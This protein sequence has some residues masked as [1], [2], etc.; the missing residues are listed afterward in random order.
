LTLR[1]TAH[2]MF[3]N[4]Q[5]VQIKPGDHDRAWMD[6]TYNRFAYRCLP[7]TIANQHGWQVQ[8]TNRIQARWNGEN[9]ERDL[10][11]SADAGGTAC[12]IFGYGILTFQIMHLIRTPPGWNLYITGAPNYV[13]PGIQPLTG[14][15]ETDWAPYS[16]TMNWQ[17][18]DADRDICFEPGDP[19]CFFFPIRRDH[20]DDWRLEFE[21]L[22]GDLRE[23]YDL[24]TTSRND[25]YSS[26][27]YLEGQWQKH[28]FQ[29]RMPDGSACPITDHRTKLKLDMKPKCPYSGE[30]ENTDSK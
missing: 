15:Y 22:A 13:K 30:H 16:F 2:E 28:Y 24:F 12:S 5:R 3:E 8:T 9:F 10:H 19:I 17:I 7:L 21:P 11:I 20:L 18:T 27:Q 26:N 29:G 23:Q 14:I 4:E 1:I 25:F 6:Q